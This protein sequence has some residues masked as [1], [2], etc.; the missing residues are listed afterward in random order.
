MKRAL[1]STLFT[2]AGVG[3]RFAKL[4]YYFPECRFEFSAGVSVNYVQVATSVNPA[5]KTVAVLSTFLS[6]ERSLP[7]PQFFHRTPVK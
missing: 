6:T 5:L 3:I 2:F 4:F 7:Y 1:R